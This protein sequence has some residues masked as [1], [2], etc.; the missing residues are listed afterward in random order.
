MDFALSPE[1]EQIRA[2]ARDFADAE[3]APGARERDRFETFPAD[4]LDE[5]GATSM[6][7]VHDVDL[8]PWFPADRA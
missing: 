7:G 3:I 2:L 4:V 5:S 1:Q 8:E 6:S